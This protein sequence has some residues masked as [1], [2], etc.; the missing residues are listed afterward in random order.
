MPSMLLLKALALADPSA[1]NI[2]LPDLQVISPPF[3]QVS[4]PVWVLPL[5]LPPVL[6]TPFTLLCVSP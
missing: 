4:A 6:P 1:W 5:H 2:L 3:L